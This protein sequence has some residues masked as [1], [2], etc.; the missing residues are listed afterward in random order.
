MGSL[1]LGPAISVPGNSGISPI[2][3][4]VKPIFL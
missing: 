4:L 2:T 1:A 3:G